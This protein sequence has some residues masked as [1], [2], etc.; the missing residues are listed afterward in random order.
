MEQ[1]FDIG[2]RMKPSSFCFRIGGTAWILLAGLALLSLLG[3]H[4]VNYG[5]QPGAWPALEIALGGGGV[6]C[7]MVGGILSLWER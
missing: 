1:T 5:I 2:A 7:F 6:L 3:R 4:L